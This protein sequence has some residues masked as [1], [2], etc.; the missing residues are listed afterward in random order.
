MTA[1]P[2]RRER[3][4][5]RFLNEPA[6]VQPLRRCWNWLVVDWQW[7]SASLFAAITLLTVAPLWF[8]ASGLVLGCVF[9]QLPVYLLHQW[10]EHRGDRFRL[11]INRVIGG[12]REA[13]TPA[14]TFW[15]N[16][17]G[18]WGVD[19]A[20]L[21]LAVFIDPALGLMAIY[22][23][24]LNSLGHIVPAVIRREYNPGLWTTL[25]L[26]LPVSGACAVVVATH[27][28]ACWRAQ[29][30]SL[31]VALAVHAAIIVHVRRRLS[32]PADSPANA[33]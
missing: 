1:M 21:Y 11:Y 17:L 10:E 19:L 26:F 23:P 20:A 28:H 33:D 9:L 14:A 32:R 3:A 8:A 24:L 15:I 2:A 18:V 31:G 30:V 6:I 25:G 4:V 5:L 27:S 29:T 22:L 12:G 13:L 16:A 7:P